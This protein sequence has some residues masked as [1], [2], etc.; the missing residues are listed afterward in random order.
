MPDDHRVR[1]E[2]AE[3]RRQSVVAPLTGQQGPE[4]GGAETF[5][6]VAL[7]GSERHPARDSLDA[8]QQWCDGAR[9]H[10]FD[11]IEGV[12]PVDVADVAEVSANGAGLCWEGVDEFPLVLGGIGGCGEVD[13]WIDETVV[14][15]RYAIPRQFAIR[16]VVEIR[17]QRA[18][19][20]ELSDVMQPDVPGEAVATERVRQS[21]R[22][23]VFLQHEDPLA[24]DPGEQPCR[25]QSTYTRSDD[26]GVVHP[27]SQFT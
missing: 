12:P 10:V 15:A 19:R 13:A 14:G 9:H 4:P 27:C 23:G 17:A 20:F 16:E 18:A 26:D 8:P 7:R 1:G 5:L 22:F 25:G 6:Q 24:R 2:G 21:A 3:R 11:E